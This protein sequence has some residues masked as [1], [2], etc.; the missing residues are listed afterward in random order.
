MGIDAVMTSAT[1][2]DIGRGL[3]L[4]DERTGL[5]KGEG[6]RPVDL[7]LVPQQALQVGMLDACDREDRADLAVGRRLRGAAAGSS[8]PGR[9]AVGP[10]PW[11]VAV[12]RVVLARGVH[13][14]AVGRSLGGV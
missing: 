5:R 13:I 14:M 7:V 4:V 2:S 1:G 3:E 6:P 10:R 12:H 8:G 11:A 9:G